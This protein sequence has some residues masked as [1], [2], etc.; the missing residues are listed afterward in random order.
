[1]STPPTYGV[2][3]AD[4][5]VSLPVDSH[6]IP[7]TGGRLSLSDLDAYIAQGGAEL[8]GLIE[9][10]GHDPSS[11]PSATLLQVQRDIVQYALAEALA[12][13]GHGGPM[14]TNARIKWEA[15]LTR[16]RRA[17]QTVAQAPS[18]AMSNIPDDA[19]PSPWMGRGFKF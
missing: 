19:A 12:K 15:A 9:F 14:L 16:W 4:V 1:M 10:A 8:T 18:T 11:L 6:A 7:A 17:P 5:L 2:T 13:L 3:A